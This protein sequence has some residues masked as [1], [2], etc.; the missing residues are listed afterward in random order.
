MIN[1]TPVSEC[2]CDVCK[3][4]KPTPSLMRIIHESVWGYNE[5]LNRNDVTS[6]FGFK[7][8]FKT[9]VHVW[10]KH[11]KGAP[12]T[13]NSIKDMDD[14]DILG[15]NYSEDHG[16]LD[17]VECIIKGYGSEL[18]INLPYGDDMEVHKTRIR[19]ALMKAKESVDKSI[20]ESSNGS[21]IQPF[22]FKYIFGVSIYKHMIVMYILKHMESNNSVIYKTFGI[23]SEFDEKGG[24]HEQ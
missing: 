11:N 9:K 2:M 15:F 23:K 8:T 5:D 7:I 16:Y 18:L 19:K 10:Y 14:I 3:S 13:V 4:R 20:L 22:L 12:K 21:Y 6:M 17:F 1:N 24:I